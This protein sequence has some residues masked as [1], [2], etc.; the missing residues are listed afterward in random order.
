MIGRICYTDH[1]GELFGSDYFLR[2][3]DAGGR[4]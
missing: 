2:N 3:Y 1:F 4:G